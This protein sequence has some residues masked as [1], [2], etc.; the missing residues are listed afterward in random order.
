MGG[1]IEL[2]V[3]NLCKLISLMGEEW[4]VNNPNEVDNVAYIIGCENREHKIVKEI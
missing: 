1:G 2:Q 4:L 3:K